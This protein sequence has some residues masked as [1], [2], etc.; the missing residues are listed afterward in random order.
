MEKIIRNLILIFLASMLTGC[1]QSDPPEYWRTGNKV[2]FAGKTWTIKSGD[3]LGPGPNA[4]SSFYGDV[5][6]D[7]DGRL[8]MKIAKHDEKWYA[9]EV[10]CEENTGYGTYTF[11]VKG[12]FVNMPENLVVGL[13]TWDTYTFTEQANSEVDIEFSKWGNTD[14]TNTL[15]YSVQPVNF[16]EYYPERSHHVNTDPSNIIGVSTHV[17]TW[18]DTLI[19]WQ[20][21]V[22][23]T[24]DA[25]KMFAS[26]EFDDSNPAR[27]KYE[28]DN[29]SN[30]VV[31]PAPG[32]STNARI[33]F[34]ILPHISP[35]PTDEMEHEIIIED[36]QYMPLEN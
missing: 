33:N 30:P 15:T 22:G 10:V 16:G 12:D 20:S 34:W 17:F 28:G 5:F 23:A 36:Y 24:T 2:E 25:S 11:T 3:N 35:A 9:T 1:Q 32:D 21:Y 14:S 27:I 18:T 31:I 7:E 29:Q 4:F 19:S 8:H 6:V 26:W 13:F